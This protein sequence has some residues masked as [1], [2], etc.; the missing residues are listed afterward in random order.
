MALRR[1]NAHGKKQK[2]L[3]NG[4]KEMAPDLGEGA[5]GGMRALSGEQAVDRGGCRRATCT[6]ACAMSLPAAGPHQFS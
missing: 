6:W 4:G 3:A 2:E 5:W 1:F